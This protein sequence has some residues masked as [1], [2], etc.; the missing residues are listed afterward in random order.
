MATPYAF[1]T[2]LTSDSYLPGALTVAAALRDVHTTPPTPPEVDFHTVCL[3]TPETVDVS[4][5]K[6]LRRAFNVVIGVEIIEEN[7]ARGLHLLGRPD[8]HSVLTKLHVFRLI[9]Y[10][11][12]VFLDA[13]ILPTR[14]LSH[15]FTLPYEFAAVPDVG[16]PDIFNSGLMLLTPREA[17]FNELMDLSKS[18]GSWDGGDQGLLNEWRGNDWHRL[19]FTYNTTPTAAYTYAPAYERFG[20]QISSIHFIGPNKPWSSIPWRAPGSTG[21]HQAASEPPRAYDY[22]SLVDRWYAVYDKHYRS[23][24]VVPQPEYALRRYEP[25]WEQSGGIGAE[26]GPLPALTAGNV[27]G[28]DDLRRIAVEGFTGLSGYSQV[29][30][31]EGEYMRL[32]L[33]GRLDLMRPRS[34]PTPAPVAEPGP[35][36]ELEGE[37]TPQQKQSY[38]DAVGPS[39]PVAH[40]SQFS[41][42]GDS[43]PR[44]YTLPTPGPDELPPAPHPHALSLPPSAPVTPT[45]SRSSSTYMP[46]QIDPASPWHP[47]EPD[48]S[49]ENQG[50]PYSEQLQ[51]QGHPQYYIQRPII[52]SPRY[53]SQAHHQAE[54]SQPS[55]VP[56]E[57]RQ[58][59]RQ[60]PETPTHEP[61]RYYDHEH[62][63]PPPPR[64]PPRPR[65]PPMLTWNP[66]IE[67]P[68]KDAPISNFPTD[69]YFPNVWDRSTDSFGT[70]T[71]SLH[72]PTPPS[73]ALFSLP[74]PGQIPERLLREGHYTNVL[75]DQSDTTPSPDRKKVRSVFPW[76]TKPRHMPGRVFPSTDS[77]PPGT[78]MTTSSSGAPSPS[79]VSS[80]VQPVAH[81]PLV[82][83]SP[84][85]GLPS[86]F[87]YTNAWDSIPSIQKYASKL[88][89]P[90]QPPARPLAP[91]FDLIESRKRENSLFKSEWEESGESSVD[92]DDEDTGDE[93]ER[94]EE[95]KRRSRAGSI[96]GK[97]KKKEYRMVGVQTVPKE[98]RNQGVQ[99]AFLPVPPDADRLAKDKEGRLA[100]GSRVRGVITPP[101]GRRE[102]S[103]MAMSDASSPVTTT[104]GAFMPAHLA[105]TVPSGTKKLSPLGSPTGLRS[106]RMY[107][108]PRGSPKGSSVNL[109]GAVGSPPRLQLRAPMSPVVRTISSDA[110][111]SSSSSAGPPQSP[112]LES[113]RPDSPRPDSPRLDSPRLDSPRNSTLNTPMRKTAARVW[114]PARGVEIFKKGSEEVL[115][116][117]LRMGSWDE[118]S[119]EKA[120]S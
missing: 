7:N 58:Q 15:L 75:G 117:F 116:K 1:V 107:T 49:Q 93:E 56:P 22:G 19:S 71:G 33:E 50:Q 68:P 27:L 23:T 16:W 55:D 65:S 81:S 73:S 82:M 21:A 90:V 106:P 83:H 95:L 38:F 14:P 8:L 100:M 57:R 103:P 79:L 97:G 91:A 39:T 46:P 104:A 44:M 45:P 114:D 118:E 108:S 12:I 18:K 69:T 43:P 119:V 120:V 32:P 112:R 99:V 24:V 37:R 40:R 89:R 88:V 111:S 5:I 78:F 4:S 115:A 54:P 13:D 85:S 92:G 20:S 96:S 76:E 11:K 31:G 10:S 66:A 35:S 47:R 53:H 70:P 62:R 109:V 30:P 28:L 41:V 105:D 102:W 59:L 25:A 34:D 74:P 87:M 36:A 51:A 101:M 9:Q 3:V 86:S 52:E 17:S 48:Y 29:L 64:E 60:Q 63:Q 2:L 110:T 61:S 98:T 67:P 26:V 80:P 113:L 6:L 72:S 94:K 84:L 42:T 77:P